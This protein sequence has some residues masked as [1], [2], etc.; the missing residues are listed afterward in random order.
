MIKK[1]ISSAQNLNHMSVHLYAMVYRMTP[2]L[3]T[4]KCP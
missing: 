4:A 2:A 1:K 3:F